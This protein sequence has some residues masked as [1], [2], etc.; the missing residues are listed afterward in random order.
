MEKDLVILVGEKVDM[1][2]Q[3]VLE[4]WKANN[5][6][7]HQKRNDQWGEGGD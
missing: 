3:C 6:G 4:D 7:W 1:S 5:V 2:Q